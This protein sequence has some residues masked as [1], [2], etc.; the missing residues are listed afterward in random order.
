LARMC[1][2]INFDHE[3]CFCT[4]EIEHVGPKQ[5]LSA[6]LENVEL[7]IS[8]FLPKDPFS[9]RLIYSQMLTKIFLS[10]LIE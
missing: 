1:I 9:K 10:D 5:V 4:V 6:K 2:T 3:L 8:Q 7:L